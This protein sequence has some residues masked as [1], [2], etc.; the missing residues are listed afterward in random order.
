MNDADFPVLSLMLIVPLLGAMITAA[1]RSIKLA[2]QLALAVAVLEL[3]LSLLVLRRFNAASA[4]FQLVEKQAWIPSLN[5]EYLIGIDGI[6]VL[7]LPLSAL[8]T[9]MV[10]GASWHSVHQLTRLHFALLLEVK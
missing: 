8:L 2:K 3:L 9:L 6:S 1:C 4:D 10:I 5:I 7:F